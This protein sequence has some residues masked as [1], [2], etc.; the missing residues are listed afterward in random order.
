MNKEDIDSKIESFYLLT[1][2]FPSK[3][4]ILN[5]IGVSYSSALRMGVSLSKLFELLKL[6][7]GA[8]ILPK[9]SQC[10]CEF[11]S[12]NN[13]AKFCSRSCSVTHA[14]NSKEFK[15]YRCNNCNAEYKSKANKPLY[16]SVYCSHT[17]NIKPITERSST[18]IEGYQIK[19]ESRSPDSLANLRFEDWLVNGNYHT[20]PTL[21]KYLTKSH[22]YSC[23]CCGLSDWNGKPITLE[24]EHIDGNHTNCE[25]S[26]VCLLCP[27]CHSQTS[28]YKS[29]NKGNG[30]HSR[31]LRYNE[32]KSY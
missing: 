17:S 20:N 2:K 19:F 3:K 22:G 5:D 29:K 9:C 15:I 16:C 12:P 10:N 32:G 18:S 1:G 4:T 31:R 26:N 27:N 11:K 21:R 30:R 6:N 8:A 13:K 14:N 23:R 28:T 24:V 25:P 7:S